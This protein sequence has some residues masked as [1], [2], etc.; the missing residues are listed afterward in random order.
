MFLNELDMDGGQSVAIIHWT[1]RKV[2]I[3]TSTG[4]NDKVS[5]DRDAS[6]HWLYA[7]KLSLIDFMAT[8]S[9]I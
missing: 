5:C 1:L 6:K 4:E 8:G 3:P 2:S 7:R 9:P